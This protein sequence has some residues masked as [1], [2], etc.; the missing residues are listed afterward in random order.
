[1]RNATCRWC[2]GVAAG[3]LAAAGI[4]GIASSALYFTRVGSGR[5][6]VL[7]G[8]A[9]VAAVCAAL[10]WPSSSPSSRA[11]DGLSPGGISCADPLRVSSTGWPCFSR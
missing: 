8:L 11:P 5:G 6:Q 4:F 10:L 3:C 7:T 1:M 9:A 2:L